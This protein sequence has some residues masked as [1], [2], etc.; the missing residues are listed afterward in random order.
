MN[1]SVQNKGVTKEDL[2]DAIQIIQNTMQ[3]LTTFEKQFTEHK[4]TETTH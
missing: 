3:A 4:D 1:A 2:N